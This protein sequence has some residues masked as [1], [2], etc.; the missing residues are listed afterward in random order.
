MLTQSYADSTGRNY[1]SKM[2]LFLTF[3]SKHALITTDWNGANPT[4]PDV[5]PIVLMFFCMF[6]VMKGMK[7]AASTAGYCSAVKQWCLL[8]D[9]PDPV[10][11]PR[12]G[13]VDVRHHRLHRAIKR[14]LGTKTSRREPL[15]VTGLRTLLAAFRSGFIVHQCMILDFVAAML[16]GFYAML[17]MSEF[18]NL[19]TTAHIQ[20]KEACRNDVSFFGPD[21]RPDGFRFVV[22]C[23][24]TD[25]FRVT[26]TLTVFRSTDSKLCPVSAMH[27][28]FQQDPRPPNAPLFDFTR[29]TDDRASRQVSAART[30]FIREFQ[31]AI[32]FAGMSTAKT[33]SHSLRSGGATA[34]LRAGVDPYIIQ[35]MGRWRSWCWQTYTWTSAIHT[36]Q[37]M[38]SVADSGHSDIVNLEQVRW[39]FKQ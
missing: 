34:H 19:T 11:N 20:F 35:R 2:K 8:N 22:K 24:K 27:A 3:L 6:M 38:E 14:R 10:L 17:R 37:A 5:T 26:Q 30:W 7:S 33:Q 29:R 18:T 36:Q 1:N 21:D 12:T 39:Q 31:G 4:I 28:L 9:R 32:I 13:T 16:L 15:S 25:Q 23:S